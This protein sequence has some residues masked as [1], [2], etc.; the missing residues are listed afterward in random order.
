M[1]SAEAAVS[2]G[3]SSAPPRSGAATAASYSINY[4]GGAATKAVDQ[5]A[6]A[7]TWVSLGSYAFT[8]NGTGQKISLAQN[9]GG[10]V[11]ADAIKVVR[12]NS[13]DIANPDQPYRHGSLWRSNR[14]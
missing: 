10:A 9:S 7:G 2:A 12:V 5:T 1:R 13:G 14:G 6:N 8:E 4:N 11:T 3:V